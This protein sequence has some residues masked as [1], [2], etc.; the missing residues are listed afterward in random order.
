VSDGDGD[1]A[2]TFG[3]EV[4][5]CAGV[6]AALAALVSGRVLDQPAGDR[7]GEDRLAGGDGSDCMDDVGG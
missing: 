6:A 1:L 2:L 4:E 7:G 3:E 5:L